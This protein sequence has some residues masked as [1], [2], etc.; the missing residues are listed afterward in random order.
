MDNETIRKSQRSQLI[1][2]LVSPQF[3]QVIYQLRATGKPLGCVPP[4]GKWYLSEDE[5]NEI[6]AADGRGLRGKLLNN[7]ALAFGFPQ[8]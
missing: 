3:E 2:Q 6:F 4:E 1:H 5:I 7:G 8:G